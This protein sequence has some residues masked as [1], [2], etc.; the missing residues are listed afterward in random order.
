MKRI[1]PRDD[2]E[3]GIVC[4]RRTL[5]V[6][7]GSL[8]LGGLVGSSAVGSLSD[9]GPWSETDELVVGFS[10]TVSN[11][12]ATAREAVPDA[13]DVR[14]ANET[15][16][17]A[18]VSIPSVSDRAREQFVEAIAATDVVEYVEPNA[19]FRTSVVP[20][21]REYGQQGAPQRVGCED[22]WETTLGSEDVSIAVIDQGVQYDHPDLEDAVTGSGADFV[23]GDDDPY[24]AGAGERHGTHVAGIAAGATDNDVGTAG[25]SNCSLLTAR[26]LGAGG[27]GSLSNVVDAIQ[28]AA[29]AGADV[30]NVSFGAPQHY[31]TLASA[32][33]YAIE[34]GALL[35]AAAG[36]EGGAV[37]Y[38]AAYPDV[39]G[40]AAL[41]GDAP[42]SYSNVGSGIDIAAPGTD[43]LSAVPW[44]GYERISGTSM[45]APVVAGVA[46]L[47][48]S[49]SPDLEPLALRDHLL[50]TATD[51]GLD[52]TRQ[53]A[54]R[55]DAAAAVE[56]APAPTDGAETATDDDGGECGD[57][58]ASASA[59]GRLEGGW[60]GESDRYRYAPRTS[61]PCSA[62]LT[63]E[64]PT[65]AD[66][67]L[68]VT[69]DG[70]S[71]SRWNHDES[72]Q[73]GSGSSGDAIDL[74]LSSDEQLRLQVHAVSGSGRYAL[75]IEERGR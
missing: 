16:S 64:S 21:D 30:I 35:I 32:C 62:T 60:W 73:T 13:V 68:Y 75:G 43:L 37:E 11:V 55:I 61:D 52:E 56:T 15:I 66:F 26:A 74:E 67:R 3:S 2:D 34:Q 25:V 51:L 40:V 29:D 42:A 65:G 18:T 45:A 38:P 12:L 44:D 48:L 19:T 31:E 4:D 23:D 58:T 49:V 14:H 7:A 72:V 28:W 20:N 22:A 5:L 59:E 53:G 70:R 69:R 24:P 63:L 17:Y 41:E 39:I 46:G 8:A 9:R 27:D 71:P 36:N 54:G 47:V 6:G 33:E 57:E 50:A 1:G 10:P